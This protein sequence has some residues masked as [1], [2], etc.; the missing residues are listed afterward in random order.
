MHPIARKSS[1]FFDYFPIIFSGASRA[2]PPF[3]QAGGVPDWEM[4]RVLM[5]FLTR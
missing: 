3:W 4:S 5:E 1:D 2:S